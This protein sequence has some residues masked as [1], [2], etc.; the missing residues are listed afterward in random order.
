MNTVL[1][2][3]RC[4]KA[5][6]PGFRSV[7]LMQPYDTSDGNYGATSVQARTALAPVIPHD[8]GL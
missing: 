8:G 1:A 4:L 2:W 3:Q 5:L 7:S 6:A